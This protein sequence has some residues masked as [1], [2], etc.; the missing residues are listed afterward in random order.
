MRRQQM[1]AYFMRCGME[2]ALE[3]MFPHTD[4][5]AEETMTEQVPHIGE[6][7]SFGPFVLSASERLL[8]QDGIP[9]ELGARTLDTLIALVSRPNE[10][11][12]KRDLMAEIWPDV[13]VEEGSLRFHITGLRK[14]LGDGE[15]GAR[16]IATLAGRGY[17]FVAPVSRSA[18]PL[19]GKAASATSPSGTFLPARLQRMVG[20]EESILSISEALTT[21]RF[22]TIVGPGGV[23]KTTVA[24]AIGHDL[25]TDFDGAVLFVD[26][27][28]LN[29]PAMVSASLASML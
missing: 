16:Y 6:R 8:T 13:I 22:V 1:L 19:S 2:G 5:A 25:L 20:R 17:C 4:R 9:I 26:F 14:A 15:N 21:S 3:L 27:S 11:I 10:V 28:L 23:G 18:P 7:I 12:S 29:H 24:A